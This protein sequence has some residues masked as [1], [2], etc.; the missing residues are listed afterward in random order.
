MV[1]FK[2]FLKLTEEEELKKPKLTPSDDLKENKRLSRKII[3]HSKIKIKIN[4]YNS[5]QIYKWLII[6]FAGSTTH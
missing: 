1:I 2:N 5:T 4:G 6:T 3:S